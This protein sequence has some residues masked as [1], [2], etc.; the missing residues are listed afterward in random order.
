MKCRLCGNQRR[1]PLV[2]INVTY[3]LTEVITGAVMRFVIP[4]GRTRLIAA[5]VAGVLVLG[6]LSALAPTGT[7]PRQVSAAMSAPPPS[8]PQGAGHP[9]RKRRPLWPDG[10]KKAPAVD[11]R[12]VKCVALTFDDGPGPY[13]RTLLDT[14]AA[15]HAK[16]TFF[17]IGGNIRGREAVVRRELADGHAIGDHTWSHPDL[18]RLPER[19][20]RSQLTRTLTEISRVTGGPTRLMRPP[21]GATDRHVGAVAR[22][23]KLTQIVW[24]VDTNDWLDRNSAIVAHRAISRAHRGDIILM[25]DIHPTT[26]K[27]VPKI[28]RGLRKRG[29]TF[30]TVPQLLAAHPLKPG[31]VYFDGG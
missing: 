27:A 7:G 17:L 26:V 31:K 25:H 1:K 21:Y 3:D 12:A 13:T 22:R 4:A 30:V 15:Q 6:W 5:A 16:V 24:S 11:C 19:A 10:P 20:V 14:L 2:R 9:V 8:A 18:S 23:L 28:L 29:F